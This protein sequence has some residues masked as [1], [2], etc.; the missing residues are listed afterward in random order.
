MRKGWKYK[1]D[2]WHGDG[3]CD[4]IEKLPHVQGV[5][6]TP[7]ISLE[8]VQIFILAVVFGW[9]RVEY[10]G[11]R[12]S[13][14]YIEMARTGAEDTLTAGVA[15]YC[16]CCEDEPGAEIIIGATTG[17]QAGKVFNPAKRMVEMTP[18]LQEAFGLS[19]W[20]RSVTCDQNGGFIQPINANG[21]TQ[22]GWNPHVGILD[23]LHAHPDWALYDVIASAFGARNN[24][25]MW[26]ITTAGF[27]TT[28]VCYQQNLYV[29]NV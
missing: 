9:R 19:A 4:F 26:V 28:G 17:E 12:F 21:K 18:A 16:L 24:P 27:D 11:L 20:A 2:N 7:T 22:D 6:E 8:P 1:F 13:S 10:G 14:A 29:K 23:E 3:I 15:L 5:W 25:L